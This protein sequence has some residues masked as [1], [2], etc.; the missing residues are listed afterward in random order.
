MGKLSLLLDKIT[1]VRS[2]IAQFKKSYEGKIKGPVYTKRL[3]QLTQKID[4]LSDQLFFK[5]GRE[6]T[7]IKVVFTS[8]KYPLARVVFYTDITQEDAEMLLQAS[9]K[10]EGDSNINILSTFEIQPG[11]LLL[12]VNS[13]E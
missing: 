6:H 2:E 8:T 4:T 9:L 13:G 3:S 7:I 5:V 11:K 10:R 1:Y 12:K